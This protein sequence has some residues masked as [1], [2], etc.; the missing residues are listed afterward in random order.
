LAAAGSSIPTA[1]SAS[2]SGWCRAC[3]HATT[4]WPSAIPVEPRRPPITGPDDVVVTFVGHAT[5]LIQ[6]ATT[7]LLTDLV[8]S[9]RARARVSR[10]ISACFH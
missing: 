10:C 5:F 4:R 8:Y 1:R 2:P 9:E 3:A 7:N 6:V